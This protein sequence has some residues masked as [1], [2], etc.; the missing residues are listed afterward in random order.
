MKFRFI[1]LL[2]LVI[3]ATSC[4][5]ERQLAKNF[6]KQAKGMPV[7]VF[8]PPE[9]F[10]VNQKH[11]VNNESFLFSDAVQDTSLYRYSYLLPVLNE[12]ELLGKFNGAFQHELA[13]YG[14]KVYDT[15]SLEAFSRLESRSVQINVAQLEL[16][17]YLTSY[18]DAIPVGDDKYTKVI[19]INGINM[20]AWFELGFVNDST[21]TNFPVLY[22]SHDIYD[23]W[24]GY[25]TQRI[26]TGEV[27]YKLEIDS[28]QK[29]DVDAF[30]AYLGRLYAAYTFDYLMNAE[31]TKSVPIERKT[32][33]YYRYDPYSKTI[34]KTETD[35]FTEL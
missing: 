2:L 16:Q 19:Y 20:A 11:D 8:F 31:I 30:A 5:I 9:I 27:Q 6:V 3:V 24:N 15:S 35:R 23:R 17:E 25:F 13:N 33:F 12:K 14:C 28:L 29:A 21:N 22:A 1:L 26:L 34:F 18:E 7:L 4:S 32:S 10:V